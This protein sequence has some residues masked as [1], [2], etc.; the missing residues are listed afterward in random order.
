[1][2]KITRKTKTRIQQ[3]PAGQLLFL[4]VWYKESMFCHRWAKKRNHRNFGKLLEGLVDPKGWG[5][6][7]DE[8]CRHWGGGASLGGKTYSPCTHPHG[9][10]ISEPRTSA[11]KPRK[12]PGVSGKY[13]RASG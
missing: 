1:M 9:G 8:D 10:G 4:W 13:F 11:P 3:M 6:E 2:L 5:G 7:K 12:A